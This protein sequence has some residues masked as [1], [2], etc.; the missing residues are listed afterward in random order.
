METKDLKNAMDA[1]IKATFERLQWVYDHHKETPDNKILQTSGISRLTFPMYGPHRD[2][3]TRISE[4]ELR[5]AF[6]EEFNKYC[7]KKSLNLF[8]SAETP[9]RSKYTGVSKSKRSS[10]IQFSNDTGNG[11]RINSKGR[12]GEFDLVIYNEKMERKCLIEFKANNAEFEHHWKDFVKLNNKEEGDSS[13]LRY[14]IEVVKAYDEGTLKRLNEKL[15]NNKEH[16]AEFRCYSLEGKS[17]SK[18]KKGEE[19]TTKIIKHKEQ[20]L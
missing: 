18:Q 20:N 10:N 4:Q 14:F 12:S 17:K 16:T 2:N 13:V 6:V 15:K 9:T 8:Y 1:I 5:F 19:I 3:E 7:D 11:P